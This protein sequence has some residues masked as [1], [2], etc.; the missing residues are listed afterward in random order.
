[1][2]DDTERAMTD[3]VGDPVHTQHFK[4]YK[5]AKVLTQFVFTHRK[6]RK[7]T[8]LGDVVA[9]SGCRLPTGTLAIGRLDEDSEGLLLLTTDGKISERVRRKS[10]EKE[11]WVEVDGVM[12]DAAME[13]LRRGVDIRVPGDA[14][15]AVYTTLPSKVRMLATTP[16]EVMRADVTS[17]TQTGT[18]DKKPTKKFKGTCNKCGGLGHK[19]W[20]CSQNVPAMVETPLSRSDVRSISDSNS[21]RTTVDLPPGIPPSRTRSLSHRQ[22]SWV[23]IIVN[24]GKNRQVRKMTAAVGFPTLRLVRYRIGSITVAGMAEGGVTELTQSEMNHIIDVGI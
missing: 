8:L 6:R 17:Q 13:K 16:V 7:R 21:L 12:T 23:S 1:M 2:T 10:V 9:Q 11:Y 24:E 14:G 3:V 5:P 19:A 18:E 22:S 15:M 20:Q 4:M